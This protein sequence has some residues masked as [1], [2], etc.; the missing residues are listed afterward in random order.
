MI[1]RWVQS[2]FENL[3]EIWIFGEQF[4]NFWTIIYEYLH[5]LV[6]PAPGHSHPHLHP[7]AVPSLLEATSW[8]LRLFFPGPGFA[9]KSKAG[10]ACPELQNVRKRRIRIGPKSNFELSGG[11]LGAF[12][13]GTPS[14]WNPSMPAYVC[15]TSG[16]LQIR[17]FCPPGLQ[18]LCKC[19]V[20]LTPWRRWAD[21]TEKCVKWSLDWFHLD[22]E[23]PSQEQEPLQE[24]RF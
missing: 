10:N 21:L 19:G 17:H 7:M 13:C 18:Y 15:S 12:F 9:H 22:P 2:N 4:G 5:I 16:R 6:M 24:P 23:W 14:I 1:P 11:T 8:W 20:K 3:A